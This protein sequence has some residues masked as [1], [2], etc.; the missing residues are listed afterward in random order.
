MRTSTRRS[1]RPGW[2]GTAVAGLAGLGVGEVVAAAGGTSLIDTV[3]R[4]AVDW[5]P[6]PAVERAVELFGSRDKAA[7]RIG[8]GVAAIGAASALAGLPASVRAPA[9]ATLSAATAALALRRPPRSWATT[10]AAAASSAVATAVGLRRA[11]ASVRSE[12]TTALVA[13][14]ALLAARALLA[15]RHRQHRRIIEGAAQSRQTSAM[16]DDGAEPLPGLTPVITPIDD[17]YVTDVNLGAPLIDPGQWRLAVTGLVARPHQL[18]LTELCSQADEFDA[19]MVCIHNPVGGHRVGNGRWLGVPLRAV[20]E[21]ADPAVRATT[22]VTRAV[23]GFTASLPVQPLRSGEWSGYVAIGLNGKP[24]PAAHGFPARVFVPGIYGQYTGVKWLTELELVAGPHTDYWSPRGWPHAPA[25][26]TPHARIDIPANEARADRSVTI[27]GVAWAPPHGVGG[28]E[29]RSDDRPWQSADL[30]CAL[31]P[32]SWRRWR[33]TLDLAAGVHTI[34]ARALSLSGE[35]QDGSMRP[36]FP[37][38]ASGWHAITIY[39]SQ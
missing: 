37:L 11:P 26:I 32:S 31:A 20:L 24:L 16:P 9:V 7:I 25:W 38:G 21:R 22:L 33:T 4:A 14:G 19:V 30:A 27:A 17:F 6:R 3:G 12:V 35:W 15:R 2:R 10:I 18:S 23:D 13:G 5:S 28:V 8:V 1:R 34:Q 36:S 39:V 29:V